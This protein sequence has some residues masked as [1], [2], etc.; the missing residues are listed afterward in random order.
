MGLSDKVQF[1]HGPDSHG[2]PYRFLE[3]GSLGTKAAGDS[4][5]RE[6]S[7]VWEETWLTYCGNSEE[8]SGVWVGGE[9]SRRKWGRSMDKTGSR[10][11]MIRRSALALKGLA[12]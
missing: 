9:W 11:E 4:K 7:H 5:S 6:L 3:K 8:P 2:R 10:D 12:A 1:G